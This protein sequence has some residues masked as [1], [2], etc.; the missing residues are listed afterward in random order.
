MMITS[1]TWGFS[2]IFHS[3]S[4]YRYIAGEYDIENHRLGGWFII[5]ISALYFIVVVV[6]IFWLQAKDNGANYQSFD[7]SGHVWTHQQM[8]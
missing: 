8:R 2:W 4:A 3:Y 5:A 6:Y 1:Y 7:G